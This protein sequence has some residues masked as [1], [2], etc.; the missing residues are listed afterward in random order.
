MDHQKN[1][2]YFK[3]TDTHYYVGLAVM[4]LG[5]FLFVLGYIFWTYLFP[6]QDIVGIALLIL[7]AV[8][9]F[10]P[11]SLRSSEKDIEEAVLTVCKAHGEAVN[12]LPISRQLAANLSPVL[13]GAY[14]YEEGA[15]CRRGKIDR[16]FRSDRYT[17]SAVLFTKY[18]IYIS[19]KKFSL[20]ES[21][22]EER[23]R[24]ISYTDMDRIESENET[25]RFPS[26]ERTT[27][28]YLAIY[29][30]DEI[31][32]RIPASPDTATQATLSAVNSYIQRIR[33]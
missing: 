18:G 14:D 30:N 33:R 32:D 12:D 29:R 23:T 6:Y 25:Y 21:W 15:Y 24:E 20:T 4:A 13:T 9:A 27:L 11:A 3:S 7:G 22:E 19:E 26:G 8:I 28:T 2:K 1:S 16:K 10:I 31:I 5:G 17:V